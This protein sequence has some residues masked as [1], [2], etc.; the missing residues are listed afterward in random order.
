MTRPDLAFGISDICTS[1]K[2]SRAEDIIKA[3]KLLK[4]AKEERL[5]FTVPFQSWPI[6]RT[7]NLLYI[8]M[9]VLEI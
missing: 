2:H 1:Q 8:K 5:K 4:L 6:L 7:L 9:Q 3:N